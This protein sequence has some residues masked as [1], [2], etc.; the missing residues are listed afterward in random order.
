MTEESK[1]AEGAVPTQPVPTIGEKPVAVKGAEAQGIQEAR[2]EGLLKNVDPVESGIPQPMK[3]EGQAIEKQDPVASPVQ[4]V[5]PVSVSTDGK[6]T[7]ARN[8]PIGD[9]PPIRADDNAGEGDV[10]KE[11]ETPPDDPVKPAEEEPAEEPEEKQ[12]EE[13]PAEETV[14]EKAGENVEETKKTPELERPFGDP[15]TN[16]MNER[17]EDNEDSRDQGGNFADNI[18]GKMRVY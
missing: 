3:V 18:P 2:N 9:A 8:S 6:H 14:E 4:Q 13:E 15:F 5:A 10:S 1:N 17:R 11:T 7:S 16:M 12:S